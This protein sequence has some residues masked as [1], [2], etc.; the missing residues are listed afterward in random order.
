MTIAIETRKQLSELDA[1]STNYATEFVAALLEAA[2]KVQASDVHLQ[3][4]ASG[5][6]IRWR[7]DGVLQVVGV[8]QLGESADIVSRL[9]VLAE[10]LTYRTDVPQ[11][12]RIRDA[13]HGVEI[14]GE[15]YLLPTDIIA[16][17]SG[18]RDFIKSE[19]IAFCLSGF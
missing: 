4:C 2:C 19:S 1:K 7:L 8:F 16:P 13:G 10:L 3:P 14:E 6:E 18:E 15:N 17:T 5:L 11:E 9:K 12:G